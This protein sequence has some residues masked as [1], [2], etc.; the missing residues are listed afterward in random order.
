LPVPV[1]RIRFRRARFDFIF[2]I[3]NLVVGCRLSVVGPMTDD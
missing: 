2:G 1:R 3:E